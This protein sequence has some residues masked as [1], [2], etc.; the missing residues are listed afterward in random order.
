MYI[1]YSN[2]F[3]YNASMA[4]KVFI[5]GKEGT[6]GLKIFERFEKR[7]D[8]EI[9]TIDDDKRKDPVEK[10]KMINSSDF[11][12]LCL[13]DAA[14]IESAELCTNPKTRIIDASTAHRTNPDWAYGFPELGADFRKKIETSN[15]VAVPGCYASGSIAICYPL[16]KSGIMPSDYPVVI[17]AVSGYSGA[18]KKAIAQYEA[19]GRDPGLDSPRLYAL[20]QQHKHLPE[21]KKISGLDFEPIF[22]PYVCDYFQGMT[23]TVGLH[24][25][26]LSKKVTAKDVQEMFAAHYEGSRFVQVAP[27]MGEGILPE[28]F[29]PANTLA[30]TNNMQVFVY[31]NDDR[32]MITTRFDN[33]GKGASGA[34]VQCMN[35]MMGISEDTGL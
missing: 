22:N 25:R 10:A 35:I 31:G 7:T 2:S 20:T 14:A 23:V 6:T 21:I 13:P 19:E 8:I 3:L 29:I 34:A 1:V 4:Y 11:T 27:L 30:G 24:A 15:R 33:L 5:D 9:I 18:G 12:F 28:Q 16:V 26:L 17:H 32:I